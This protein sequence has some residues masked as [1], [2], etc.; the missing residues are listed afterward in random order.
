MRRFEGKTVMITG[1]NRG[2]GK[3]ILEAFAREGAN[4]IACSRKQSDSFDL[5][6]QHLQSEY[7]VVIKQLHFD[8]SS[9]AEIIKAVSEFKTWKLPLHVLVNN[10]GMAKFKGFMQFSTDEIKEIFQTNFFS[11][12]TLVQHLMMPLIKAKGA[13]IV[14]V[15]SIAGL[16]IAVGNTAY[17]TS[18]AALMALTKLLSK[19][20]ASMKI[21]VNCV[22]PGFIDTDM[23]ADIKDH[24]SNIVKTSLKRIGLPEE[25]ANTILFLAGEE[26]SYI[27]GQII[28]I[29]G[30]L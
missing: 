2:I 26:S 5:F 27:T 4:I 23:N 18:K 13:T 10:A 24:E 21:R 15:G 8:L 29:D 1:C 19:E 7:D 14:N 20:M 12:I 9:E 16:D 6:L 25:V 30:G 3:T 22:A 11:C 17:G 28:R